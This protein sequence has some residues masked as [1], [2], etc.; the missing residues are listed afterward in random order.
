MS[1]R[2]TALDVIIKW[3]A[4]L[5]KIYLD[6]IASYHV[7]AKSFV[8][9]AFAYDIIKLANSLAGF[10]CIAKVY[11]IKRTMDKKNIFKRTV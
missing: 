11:T 1:V 6:L 7:Y 10:N 2:N 8:I 4:V 3:T 5:N 9:T